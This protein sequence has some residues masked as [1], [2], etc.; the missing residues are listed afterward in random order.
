MRPNSIYDADLISKVRTGETSSYGT[1]YRRHVTAAHKLARQLSRSRA[2]SDDLVSEAFIR[3]LEMLRAGGGPDKAF[4]AYL[5]TALR[6]LAYDKWSRDRRLELIDDVTKINGIDIRLISEQFRDTVILAAERS[7]A[8]RAFAKL[9]KRWRIVLWH[10]EVKGRCPTEVAPLLGLTPNG[11]SALAYRAREGL[12]EAYLQAHLAE[13][14]TDRCRAAANKLSAWTRGNLSHRET[15]H[16]AAHM[17][18]CARCRASA[19]E[20]AAVNADFGN[21][22]KPSRG[23]DKRQEKAVRRQVSGYG[24]QAA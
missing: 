5:L 15:A 24:L 18:K 20:L 22:R 16:V 6:H 12:R 2:D 17:G 23:S 13:T 21:H 4:R 1:L 7:M 3:V 9:P 19:L 10:T 14:T 11:V 8:A